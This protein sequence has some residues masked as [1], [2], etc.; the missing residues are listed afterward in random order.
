MYHI[1]ASFYRESLLVILQ[2]GI[3]YM[4]EERGINKRGHGISR[5]FSV[6]YLYKLDEVFEVFV[7]VDGEFVV[8]VLYVVVLNLPLVTHTQRVVP[9]KISTLP[10]EK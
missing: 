4:E 5:Y 7:F 9:G 8:L 1:D 10:H 3:L 6:F 2:Y